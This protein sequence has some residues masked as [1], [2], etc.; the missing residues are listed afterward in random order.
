MHQSHD[1]VTNEFGSRPSTDMTAEL[2]DR[3]RQNFASVGHWVMDNIPPGTARD[4]A[5]DRLRE[6]MMWCVEGVRVDS[7]PLAGPELKG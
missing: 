7:N 5:M 3:V 6:T 1:R 2:V 4:V